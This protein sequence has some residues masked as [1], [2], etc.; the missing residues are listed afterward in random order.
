MG[1]FSILAGT[2]GIVVTEIYMAGL[3]ERRD[4][5]AAGSGNDSI[6]VTLAYLGGLGLLFTVR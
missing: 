3:L 6:A 1:A 2:L 5:T 4:P